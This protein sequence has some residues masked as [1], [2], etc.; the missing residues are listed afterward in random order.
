[1]ATLHRHP[2]VTGRAF[3]R[4]KAHTPAI[5]GLV[6]TRSPL[7]VDDVWRI[8]GLHVTS[9]CARTRCLGDSRAI[10]TTNYSGL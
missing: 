6:L 1:M 7:A 2:G 8:N 4:S 9:M 3:S 10:T 5:T